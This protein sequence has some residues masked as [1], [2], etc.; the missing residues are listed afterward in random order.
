[1]YNKT[2]TFGGGAPKNIDT[3]HIQSIRYGGTTQV[4]SS[5]TSVFR[6]AR[7]QIERDTKSIASS[8]ASK[9]AEMFAKIDR[10]ERDFV[11]IYQHKQTELSKL[12]AIQTQTGQLSEDILSTMQRTIAKELEQGI[13]NMGSEIEDS[14]VPDYLIVINWRMSIAP[15]LQQIKLSKVTVSPKP[16]VD[17]KQFIEEPDVIVFPESELYY[18]LLDKE[19]SINTEIT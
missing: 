2:Q 3:T 18:G 19:P 10:L 12:K 1:M 8:L 16:Q 6:D 13:Q 7:A 17:L 14:K 4:A 11:N 9:K 15:L 5:I